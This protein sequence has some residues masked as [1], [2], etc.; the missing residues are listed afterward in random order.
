VAAQVFARVLA[1][2]GHAPARMELVAVGRIQRTGV[3]SSNVHAGVRVRICRSM[4]LLL[5]SLSVS[6]LSS[7]LAR[8]VHLL[9]SFLL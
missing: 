3:P 2:P 5:A 9:L 6:V 7:L 1:R 4:R 8:T